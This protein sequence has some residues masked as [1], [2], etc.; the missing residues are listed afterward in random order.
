MALLFGLQAVAMVLVIAIAL[1]VIGLA[2][3]VLA[4]IVKIILVAADWWPWAVG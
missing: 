3:L 4:A 2:L 1:G